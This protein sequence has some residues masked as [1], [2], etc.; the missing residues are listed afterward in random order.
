M[1]RSI[2]PFDFNP[3]E[4]PPIVV[5]AAKHAALLN[6]FDNAI[7]VIMALPAVENAS[8]ARKPLIDSPD[9]KNGEAK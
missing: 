9:S 6:S 4:T 7:V 3:P 5:G 2:S 1:I 8:A